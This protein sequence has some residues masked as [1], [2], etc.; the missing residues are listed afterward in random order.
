ME[1][2]KFLDKIVDFNC[3]YDLQD[4]E[5]TC[6]KILGV[7]VVIFKHECKV[8]DVIV[9]EDSRFSSED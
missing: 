3:E 9:L 2:L 7:A 5:V 1:F 4:V 6:N 8:F